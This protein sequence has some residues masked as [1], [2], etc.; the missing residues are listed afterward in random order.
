MANALKAFR[1]TLANPARGRKLWRWTRRNQGIARANEMAHAYM[2]L[3]EF[4][5]GMERLGSLKG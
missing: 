5:Y 3:K 2:L 1:R 4:C